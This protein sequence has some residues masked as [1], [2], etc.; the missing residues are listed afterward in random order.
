MFLQYT[1]IFLHS[2]LAT[3]GSIKA[4][5]VIFFL[6]FEELL[7]RVKANEK[8]SKIIKKAKNI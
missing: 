7:L 6:I 4:F 8:I 2:T 1:E 3:C 5:Y